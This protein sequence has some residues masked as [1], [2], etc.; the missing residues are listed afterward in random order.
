MEMTYS[1]STITPICA[2]D[3]EEPTNELPLTAR[4]KAR[5]SPA[6]AGPKVVWVIVL[7]SVNE[8]TTPVVTELMSVPDEV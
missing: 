7:P 2:E 3:E 8:T 5:I 6:L 4:E 1:A